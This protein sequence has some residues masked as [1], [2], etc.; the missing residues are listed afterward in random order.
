M[1]GCLWGY[2]STQGFVYLNTSHIKSDF[3]PKRTRGLYM[4]KN[5][6]VRMGERSTISPTA[7][8]SFQRNLFKEIFR[9]CYAYIATY[10]ISLPPWK[11]SNSPPLYDV[12]ANQ[13]ILYTAK[14]KNTRNE[15]VPK[16]STLNPH[17][18]YIYTRF[19]QAINV[20]G[21]G[22]AWDFRNLDLPHYRILMAI[23]SDQHSNQGTG[24]AWWWWWQQW[25][26]S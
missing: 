4:S 16:F 22:S 12:Y 6:N 15:R 26:L 24:G 17:T 11:N 9:L 8:S 3:I 10:L 19:G 5:I 23:K 2:F 14:I 18:T 25:S 7:Q 20:Q 13:Y 1:R 21:F